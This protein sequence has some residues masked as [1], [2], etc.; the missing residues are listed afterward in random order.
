MNKITVDPKSALSRLLAQQALL[1]VHALTG[2]PVSVPEMWIRVGST[3]LDKIG[4]CVKTIFDRMPWI[5]KISG[6][7]EFPESDYA[8]QIPKQKVVIP[9][10]FLSR[11]FCSPQDVTPRNV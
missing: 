11:G 3:R 9:K 7:W 1:E 4:F 5:S 10:G 8:I 2:V 6:R